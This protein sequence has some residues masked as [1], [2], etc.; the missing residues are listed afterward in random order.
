MFHTLVLCSVHC[1][2]LVVVFLLL[3]YA[4]LY[5]GTNCTQINAKLLKVGTE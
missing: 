1:K 2:R 5:Y 4:Y 3:N